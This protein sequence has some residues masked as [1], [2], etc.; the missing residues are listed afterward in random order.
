MRGNMFTSGSGGAWHP[1]SL[2]ALVPPGAAYMKIGGVAYRTSGND[3]LW[4]DDFRWSFSVPNGDFIDGDTGWSVKEPG[5]NIVPNGLPNPDLSAAFFG[6]T[7]GRIYSDARPVLRPGQWISAS[8]MVQRNSSRSGGGVFIHF[9]DAN[10]NGVARGT[11]IE[12]GSGWQESE[13]GPVQ[14][15]PGA[16]TMVIGGVAYTSGS[17]ALVMDRF[18]WQYARDEDTPGTP[19]QSPRYNVPEALKTY[20]YD[21]DAENRVTVAH[22]KL[23]NGQIVLGNPDV[24]YGLAYDGAGRAVHRLFC[25]ASR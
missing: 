7:A 21:Y 15:P 20:W 13:L 2:S 23:V 12:S 10:G 25:K 14:V 5:W 24:S 16:V 18:T 3:P 22:G 17:S 9:L 6:P 8:A 4:M 1:S 11:M 19:S